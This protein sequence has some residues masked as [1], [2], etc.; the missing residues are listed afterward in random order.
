MESELKSPLCWQHWFLALLLLLCI[1]PFLAISAFAH[2]SADDWYMAADGRD[3]GFW[4]A[5]LMF[6]R[7]I[8]GR[9]FSSAVLYAHP[10]ANSITA[11]KLYSAAV[12]FALVPTLRWALSAWFPSA[13]RV[14]KWMGGLAG[15]VLFIWS[16]PSTSQGFFWATG[17]TGYTVAALLTTCLAA[18]LGRQSL[19]STWRPGAG[20]LALF[21][22][23]P[24]FITGCT[25]VAMALLLVHVLALNAV[26]LW[27]HRR[28][29]TPLLVVLIAT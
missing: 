18:L 29:S 12:V 23:L 10:M 28:I 15:A 2:P 20:R 3:M 16:M 5:N 14:W 21:A 1:A 24:I 27:R 13:P 25:E 9:F 17:T 6:Y 8:T 22:L 4:G 26:Y 7:D 19:D 11:F